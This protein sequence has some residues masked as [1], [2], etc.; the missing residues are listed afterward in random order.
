M[1]TKVEALQDNQKKITVT[2]DAKEVD[3]RISKQYKD[4][5]KKYNFPGFRKGKAPRPVIDNVLGKEAVVGTV[6]DDLVNSLFPLAM[7]EHD[8]IAMSK[9]E[10][11]MET[12]LVQAGKDFT[13]SAVL[14]TRPE[15]TLDN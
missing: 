3:A 2:V 12:E 14:E 13:F 4:F 8:L 9:P 10:F 11:E 5:A 6:T 1:E 7:D 15:Y